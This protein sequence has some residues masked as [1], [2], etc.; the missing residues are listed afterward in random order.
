MK[1]LQIGTTDKR[2]GAAAVSWK[3]KEGMEEKKWKTSMLVADKHS[4]DASVKLIPRSFLARAASFV[5]ANDDFFSTDWILKTSEFKEAD[6]IHCH[7]LHGRYFNLTTLSKMAAR[8]PVIWTLHDEWAITPHCA[9]TFEGSKIQNGF[10]QCQSKDTPPRILWHN[11]RYLAWRKK[12]I[13]Q[14]TPMTIVTPSKWLFDRVKQSVLGEKRVELVY[15]GINEKVFFPQSRE[16]C[17]KALD[18]PQEKR[19]VLILADGGVSNP[20]KGWK[21]A[22]EVTRNFSDNPD[23]LFLSVGNE[24]QKTEGNIRYLGLVNDPKIL[25]Q[26]YSAADVLLYTSL[27]DN[28]PLVILEAMASGLPTVS[29]D[30]GGVK[31]A[32]LDG[33]HG[34]IA[35]YLNTEELISG[36]K[37]MFSLP[38]NEVSQMKKACRE[39]ALE[40]FTSL[41]MVKQYLSLYEDVF[42][43]YKKA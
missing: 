7:N 34:I 39:R 38:V 25:A 26:Y 23:V 35:S 13:Y 32:V 17:R 12:T 40:K 28:F 42:E 30:V 5:L 10:F 29:F 36:L 33:E 20:W 6:I 3:L 4:D 31:E 22:Q 15:N 24:I 41:E 9:Y 27:A 16:A 8:K 11:E 14:Q 2:G 21:Y 18:L 19:I 37:Q 1:V 43:K